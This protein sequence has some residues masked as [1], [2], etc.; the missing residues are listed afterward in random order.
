M[1]RRALIAGATGLVGA[2]VLEALL[3][4][5]AYSAVRVLARRPL[6]LRH[7]KLIVDVTDFDRLQ[8]IRFPRVDDVFCCLGTTIAAAGSRAA[9][10]R[11]DFDYPLAIAR[12]ALAAKAR[13]FLFVSAM[14]ANARSPVFYSRVKGELEQ[15]VA[16]LGYRSAVAFRPSLL[17]GDR[18]QNRPGERAALALLQPLRF[19]VP[20]K[21]RPVAAVAVAQAMLNGAK[22]G[23]AGFTVIESD[24]MHESGERGAPPAGA[25]RST[26]RVTKRR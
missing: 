5:P 3:A 7:P 26:T 23:P 1:A 10:R 12:A 11:V 17:S 9:F 4:D 21:Y 20:R 6:A 2:R 25:R 18:Q 14:G 15:A 19:L 24:A 22:R 13:Q 8:D 16:G